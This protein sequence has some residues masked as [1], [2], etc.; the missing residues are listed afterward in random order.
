MTSRGADPF[1]ILRQFAPGTPLRHAVELV[2]R[3][4]S[5]AL[6]IV[7]SGPIVEQV[8]SGG[9]FL[10]NSAFSAQK[11]A[12]LA[13]MDGGIVL[14]D[15]AGFI[16][17]A[18]VQ[19]IPDPTIVTQETGTR[20]RTAERLASQTSKPIL[21]I[22]EEGRRFAVVHRNGARHE[23]RAPTALQADANQ[24]LNA[25]ERLRR[26]LNEAEATLT[27]REVDDVVIV[28]DVVKLIQR[29]ALVHRLFADVQRTIAEL[30][31]EGRL[32]AIQAADLIEGVD[33][34]ARLVDD[35]YAKRRTRRRRPVFERLASIPTGELYDTGRI[36]GALGMD[37]LDAVVRPRGLRV[38]AGVPR[39]PE[40]VKDALV[41]HFRDLQRLL[42]AT[43]GDLDEVE[44]VGRARARQLRTY[45]DRLHEMGSGVDP[46][47]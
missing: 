17:R 4:G 29:A 8:C 22:S 9:F 32:V 41:A 33:T 36:S 1:E 23:L 16:L 47:D 13:K 6:I 14:D 18:N 5:G 43:V 42:H 27:Q 39:L 30:G 35:D 44:G 38:L 21:A 11:M 10:D 46:S 3:Q 26:M 2:L 25:L 31:G 37:K 40:T 20:F 24:T 45:L 15:D 7:G 19:F 34:T 12:E 28:K